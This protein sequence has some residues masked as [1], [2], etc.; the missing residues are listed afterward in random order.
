MAITRDVLFVLSSAPS[1]PTPSPDVIITTQ[2]TYATTYGLTAEPP[3]QGSRITAAALTYSTV[4]GIGRAL[5]TTNPATGEPEVIGTLGPVPGPFEIVSL[6]SIGIFAAVDSNDNNRLWHTDG[7]F[8]GTY[9]LRVPDAAADLRPAH[10]TRL[11]NVVVFTGT[12][13]EGGPALWRTDGSNAGTVQLSA[14]GAV[15]GVTGTAVMGTVNG[16][17]VFATS[18]SSNRGQVLVSTD[19]TSAGTRVF[20]PAFGTSGAL[21]QSLPGGPLLLT[22][23]GG[24][25][26]TTDGVNAP[27]L[28]ASYGAPNSGVTVSDFALI[29]QRAAFVVDVTSAQQVHTQS[30]VVTDGTTAG[31]SPVG[32]P[33]QGPIGAFGLQLSLLTSFGS[34]LLFSAID[35]AT[36]A[37]AGS[38]GLWV[39]DGTSAGTFEIRAGIDPLSITVDGGR[40]FVVGQNSARNVDVLYT[41]DGTVV[42]TT[43]VLNSGPGNVLSAGVVDTTHVNVTG[44]HDQYAVAGLGGGALGIVDTVAGRDGSAS[45]PAHTIAFTDGTG[46]L[47]TTGNAEAVARIYQA[48]LGVSPDIRGLIGYTEAL[49]AGTTSLAQIA[50]SAATSP[51]SIAEHGTPSNSDFINILY[52]NAAHR[53][54]DAG[55]LAG[56]VNQLAAGVTRGAVLLGISQGY[57]SRV[58]DLGVAGQANDATVYRLYQAIVGR[59]P[60]ASGQQ[61]FSGALTGGAT[62]QQIAAAMLGSGEYAARFGN[63]SDTQFVADLF[64]NLLQRPADPGGLASLTAALASGVSRAGLVAASV[65]SDEARLV[66]SQATHDGWVYLR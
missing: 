66:T 58:N 21:G 24:S 51:Q 15:L 11:G 25:I 32:I 49:D 20:D 52:E 31:T 59:A 19:G 48:A 55:G 64:Q 43:A 37:T 13:V 33:V 8:D 27:T 4:F 2:G 39:T 38:T 54:A 23:G 35:A 22:D 3:I 12:T 60:D 56:Y 57:E 50:D 1:N 9:E 17:V 53:A 42:G 18:S 7:T 41:T 65:G 44:T 36:S 63:P 10:L 29:G 45:Y 5:D 16:R 28:V 40:A 34:R 14:G 6:G 46:V 26:Y 62:V 47:D 30:L 61:S